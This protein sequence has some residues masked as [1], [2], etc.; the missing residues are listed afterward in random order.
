MRNWN[1]PWQRLWPWGSSRKKHPSILLNEERLRVFDGSQD[2]RSYEFV[3]FDTELTGLDRRHDEIVSMAAIRIRDMRIALDESFHSLVRTK[4]R[5]FGEGTFVH[6]ITP[7]QLRLAPPPDQVLPAFI[8][9]CGDS[10][11]VGHLPELDFAFFHK[12][13]RQILGGI[14][15]NPCLDSMELARAYWKLGHKKR[16][17][18]LPKINSFNLTE[19][20]VACRLPLFPAHDALG[21]A[22]QTACLFLY[23]VG[24]LRGL[25]V[26]TFRDLYRLG[27]MR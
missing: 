17:A 15:H 10:V 20:S 1:V 9:F 25:G 5:D 11:M 14:P 3:V 13:S 7:Q 8:E 26:T 4:K 12:I 16:I 2:M 23:L 19:L 6:R 24:C 27:G 21:D 22:L 18:N